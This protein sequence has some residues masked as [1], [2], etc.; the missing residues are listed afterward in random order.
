MVARLASRSEQQ[1]T[2]QSF[3]YRGAILYTTLSEK[4]P[5]AFQRDPNQLAPSAYLSL[6]K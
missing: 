2:A 6:W 1:F 4:F 5:I 3:R